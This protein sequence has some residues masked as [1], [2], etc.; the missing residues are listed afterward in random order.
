MLRGQITWRE[1]YVRGRVWYYLVIR[2]GRDGTNFARLGKLV[3]E[4]GGVDHDVGSDNGV[5]LRDNY[6]DSR[7]R[8]GG[9]R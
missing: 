9:M 2:S 8:I 4:M 7:A 3:S 6:S 1:K 5:Q